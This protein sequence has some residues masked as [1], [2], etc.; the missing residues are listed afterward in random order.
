MFPA[1]RHSQLEAADWMEAAPAMLC[2]RIMR[3]YLKVAS[4]GSGAVLFPGDV[5]QCLHPPVYGDDD[6]ESEPELSGLGVCITSVTQN[7]S[8]TREKRQR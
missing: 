6:N 4:A 3:P 7:L 2:F 1:Q 8:H 5:L